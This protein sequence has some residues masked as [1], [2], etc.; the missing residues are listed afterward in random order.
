M[1]ITLIIMIGLLLC[2]A[3]HAEPKD[4]R[5]RQQ[6]LSVVGE[7]VSAFNRKDF[8]RAEQLYSAAYALYPSDKL[9]YSLGLTYE[10]LQRRLPAVAA[11]QRYLALPDAERTPDRTQLAREALQRLATHVGRVV[12]FGE[13]GQRFQVDDGAWLT[14]PQ[15]PVFVEPGQHRVRTEKGQEQVTVTAGSLALVK[16]TRALGLRSLTADRALQ[17]ALVLIT[18]EDGAEPPTTPRRWVQAAERGAQSAGL[19]AVDEAELAALWG[20]EPE[21]RGCSSAECQ[22]RLGQMVGARVVVRAGATEKKLPT[23]NSGVPLGNWR[24]SA[25]VFE[26]TVGEVGASGDADCSSCTQAQAEEVLAG[27][28]CQQ[29]QAAAA[30]PR[31]IVEL[32][33]V[34]PRADVFING[35]RLG[36]TPYARP[37]FAGKHDVA[38]ARLGYQTF[39]DEA[40]V[41]DGQPWSKEIKLVEGVDSDVRKVV[42]REEMLPLPLWRKAAGGA[43][44]GGGVVA[45]ISGIVLYSLDGKCTND[46]SADPVSTASCHNIYSTRGT[47]A[48]WSEAFSLR[49]RN[50]TDL[51][52][53]AALTYG[54]MAG[55]SLLIVGGV[56]GLV[57]PPKKR[58]VEVNVTGLTLTGNGFSISGTF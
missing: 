47:S 27:L 13:P 56:V 26:V 2:G 25:N 1:R 34:P 31:G 48:G 36:F 19:S 37:A 8:A 50:S 4:E 57:W 5:A 12:V 7:A 3:V 23:R 29:V 58:Q 14:L 18:A 44:I 30:R 16:L 10:R 55:G 54:L 24:L 51:W 41:S 15:P 38:V 6:A 45:L 9:Q 21:L 39:H 35:R 28:V 40:Q 46:L 17:R 42:L 53:G 52:K 43:L 22:E 20:A 33:S 11:L 49:A 32:R